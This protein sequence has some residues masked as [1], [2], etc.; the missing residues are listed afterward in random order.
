MTTDRVPRIT[1][2]VWENCIASLITAS[3]QP[4]FKFLSVKTRKQSPTEKL[5]FL[6]RR[7][8]IIK[9]SLAK[10]PRLIT[11]FQRR[12]NKKELT[13]P[14]NNVWHT[15]WSQNTTFIIK[16]LEGMKVSPASCKS[17][18]VELSRNASFPYKSPQVWNLKRGSAQ[19]PLVL[20]QDFYSCKLTRK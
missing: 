4:N 15:R 18:I 16:F 5:F 3:S 7:L 20:I 6:A 2:A 13:I 9:L 10:S 17:F 14:L 12:V 1:T 19:Y 8:A 11:R